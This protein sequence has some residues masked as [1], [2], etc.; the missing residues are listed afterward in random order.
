MHIERPNTD[1]SLVTRNDPHFSTGTFSCSWS[2]IFCR[3]SAGRRCSCSRNIFNNSVKVVSQLAYWMAAASFG[4]LGGPPA[5]WLG[6]GLLRQANRAYFRLHSARHRHVHF[7]CTVPQLYDTTRRTNLC[8]HWGGTYVTGYFS[9]V[10]DH[11]PEKRRTEGL[12]LFG[13]SGILPMSLNAVTE[14]WSTSAIGSS[15]LISM[16]TL[17]ILISGALV[18]M[19]PEIRRAKIFHRA[20]SSRFG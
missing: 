6:I 15:G 19:V 12:A 3:R 11:I 14:S 5:H 8:R 17:P 7:L 4:G 2:A 9:F 13:I 20:R 10:A 18:W 16:L 1:C